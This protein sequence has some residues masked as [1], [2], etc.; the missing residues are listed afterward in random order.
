M[1]KKTQLPLKS[2]Q[3]KYTLIFVFVRKQIYLLNKSI[4]LVQTL[5]AISLHSHNRFGGLYWSNA[6]SQ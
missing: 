5:S 1:R 2:K 4:F 3:T 6:Y